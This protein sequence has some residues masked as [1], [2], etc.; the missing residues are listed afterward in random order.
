MPDDDRKQIGL[1]NHGKAAVAQLTDELGWFDEAQDAG[2]F[3][4]RLRHPGRHCAWQYRSAG[5]D[6][7]VT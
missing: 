4:T 5:R 7:M 6:E 1:T 2:R 3:R